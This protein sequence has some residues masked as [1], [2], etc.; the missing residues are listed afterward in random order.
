MFAVAFGATLQAVLSRLGESAK[1]SSA[2]RVQA[3]VDYIACVADS[4]HAREPQKLPEIFARAASAKTRIS[5]CGSASVVIALAEFEKA[6]AEL[7]STRQ[8]VAMAE[9][10]SA[11]RK[12]GAGK[13][14]TVSTDT[15]LLILFGER[16]PH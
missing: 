14:K 13:R 3:Y 8:F 12:E 1:A 15:L 10:I 2:L 5:I 7:R 16:P 6:G 4:A 11:M 9:L